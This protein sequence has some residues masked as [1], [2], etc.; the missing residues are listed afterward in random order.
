VLTDDTGAYF[1]I[2]ETS[3]AFEATI[4]P[5]SDIGSLASMREIVLDPAENV[6][7][8]LRDFDVNGADFLAVVNT[9]GEVVGTLSERRVHRRYSDE[10]EK[11]QREMFGE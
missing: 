5:D 4:D 8:A 6:R 11:A 3:R 7:D 10:L 9:Q 2:V 1:G